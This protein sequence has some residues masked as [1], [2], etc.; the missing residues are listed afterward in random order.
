[1]CLFFVFLSHNHQK[2]PWNKIFKAAVNR[3][4]FSEKAVFLRYKLL[5]TESG[6]R[7]RQIFS[8]V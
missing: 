4:S 5:W 6:I 1:M 3:C 2:R 7:F 8:E